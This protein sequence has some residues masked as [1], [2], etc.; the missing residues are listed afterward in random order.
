VL[1]A[2]CGQLLKEFFAERRAA[3]QKVALPDGV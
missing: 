3:Q 1:A 2:E